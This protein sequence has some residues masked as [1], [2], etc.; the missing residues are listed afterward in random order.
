MTKLLLLKDKMNTKSGKKLAEKA[1]IYAGIIWKQ[2][3]TRNGME[4]PYENS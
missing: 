4:M 1:S 3:L 2:I